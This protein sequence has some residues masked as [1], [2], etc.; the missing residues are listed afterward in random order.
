[1]AKLK[2]FFSEPTNF[3]VILLV[4]A[5]FLFLLILYSGKIFNR[6]PISVFKTLKPQPTNG[7]QGSLQEYFN[8]SSE[9]SEIQFREKDPFKETCE[10]ASTIEGKTF[11]YSNT[12][13]MP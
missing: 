12:V 8:E 4:L 7:A 1:M 3:F 2:S 6:G 13:C 10:K 9:P 5:F 11:I